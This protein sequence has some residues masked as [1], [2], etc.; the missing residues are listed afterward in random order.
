MI[1]EIEER[2]RKR[3][4]VEFLFTKGGKLGIPLETPPGGGDI[5]HLIERSHIV[6]KSGAND[7]KHH[8]SAG[9]IDG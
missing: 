5:S 7:R 4:K 6:I 3:A 1:C 8:T 2:W 9:I